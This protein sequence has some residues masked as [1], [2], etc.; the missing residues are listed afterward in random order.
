MELPPLH[1]GK[2]LRRYKRFL[3]D[4]DLDDG[5]RVTAHCPNTGSMRTCWEPGAPVQLVHSDNP[6]RKLAWTLE[7]V[8]MGEGWIGVNTH[9]VNTLIAEAA[10]GGEIPGLEAL[11]DVRREVRVGETAGHPAARLDLL[12]SGECGQAYVEVKN[13]TLL[14]EGRL[15][16]PDAVSARAT[17]HLQVLQGL[18]DSGRRAV[19]LFALNRPE[20]QSFSPAESIDPVYAATLREVVANGVEVVAVRL[21]HGP[22]GIDVAGSV[23]TVL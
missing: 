4:V 16:F 15:L 3:A 2:I 19:I 17:R 6:K 23:E 12:L 13:V 14:E 18:A 5:R 11:R 22:R 8:D 21:R 20:G 9:R 7:R 1:D 10:S